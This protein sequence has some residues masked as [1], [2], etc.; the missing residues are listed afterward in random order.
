MTSGPA[1]LS[2]GGSG[3]LL[4]EP[5]ELFRWYG[6]LCTL[7]SLHA[8]FQGCSGFFYGVRKDRQGSSI[9]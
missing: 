9:F 6:A 7:G 8:L 2:R 1:S 3:M 5:R 4:L